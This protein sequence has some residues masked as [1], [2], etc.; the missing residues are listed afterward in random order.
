M[1]NNG[2]K[3]SWREKVKTLPGKPG[4]YLFKADDGRVIYVGKA[5]DLAKRVVSYTRPVTDP[6]TKALVA[7][8][9]DLDYIVTDT[10]LEALMLENILIKKEKP[11]YN[12]ILRDDKNYPYLQFNLNEPFPR[13]KVV[14]RI[15]R[16]KEGLYFGPYVPSNALYSTLKLLGRAFPLRK[17]A[18]LNFNRERPCLNYQM[19]RCLAP[20]KG[21]VSEEFYGEMV[22]QVRCF[23]EGR[24]K[25]LRQLLRGQ[26]EEASQR[27]EFEKAAVLRDKLQAIERVSERQKIIS[28]DRFEADVIGMSTDFQMI[29]F[30]VLFIRQGM[31]IG[32]KSLL[33]EGDRQPDAAELMDAFIQQLYA[34]GGPQIPKKIILPYVPANQELLR[35]WLFQRAGQR[36]DFVI[37]EKGKK[38]QLVDLANENAG[39]ALKQRQPQNERSLAIITQARRELGLAEL[40]KRIEGFDIS[41]I[42]GR[43]A[44]GSMVVW[45]HPGFLKAGYR[46][47]KIKTVSGIDDCAMMTEVLRRRYKRLSSADQVDLILIDGGKGQVNAAR[48]VLS[49]LGLSIPI[50][51]L[52]KREEEIYFPNNNQPLK[53]PASSQTLRLLQRIRDEAHRF[54]LKHH[55]KRR[56]KAALRSELDDIPGVGDIRKKALLAHFGSVSR[57][58]QA[59]LEELNKLPFLPAKVA[60]DLYDYWRGSG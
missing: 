8:A 44:V 22:R 14:R 41:N 7:A 4:V 26:M 38:R 48:K 40:P 10:E 43:Q 13:L 17:C 19:K 45:R 25:E 21:L 32:Y 29:C 34:G 6:K 59:S 12:V 9:R 16:K 15:G 55:R 30:A 42:Q 46:H 2:S 47:F 60:R 28:T 11:R 39:T 5:A 31:V 24:N 51:G 37:P 49:E 35:D 23:L 20:C 1:K 52:A 56:S 33:M 54:A 58:Q 36:V 50:L 18:S 57:I 27:L 53:L 3:I